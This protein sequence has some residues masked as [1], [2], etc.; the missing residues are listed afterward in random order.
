MISVKIQFFS[1][2]FFFMM[3]VYSF[4]ETSYPLIANLSYRDPVFK[5]YIQEV[6]KAYMDIA[7]NRD[8]NL[9]VYTYFAQKDEKLILLAARCNLPYETIAAINFLPTI[10]AVIPVGTKI[11]LPT[12]P[13][14]FIPHKAETTLEVI[15]QKKLFDLNQQISYTIGESQFYF[16]KGERLSGTER[17]FFL[18]TALRSPLPQGIL[19][20]SFGFRV[21][22]ISGNNHLHGGVDLAAPIGTPVLA[23]RVGTVKVANFDAIYGNYI[24][25]SHE[26]NTE[27]L[28]AHLDSISV[29]KNETVNR[30]A[31]I[32]K[33]GTTGASTGPH[34]HFEIRQDGQKQNINHLFV[35]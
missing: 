24:I 1:F 10:D 20:S 29:K 35:K 8:I 25:M 6:E 19:T 22:P 34:L 3:S 18:D 5:Q 23:A 17:A 32:G 15:L 2:F 14:L 28:Y 30:G 21:S 13:G 16:L 27:S 33:V 31:V 7:Q 11:Y 12:V 9:Q 26:N 4:G